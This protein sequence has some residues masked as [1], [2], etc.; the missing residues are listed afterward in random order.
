MSGGRI[1]AA[2]LLSVLFSSAARAAFTEPFEIVSNSVLVDGGAKETHFTLT[3]NRPPDF[4]GFDKLGRPNN[5]FQYF[6]DSDPSDDADGIFSGP[7]VVIIRG[8]EIR[9]HDNIPIRDS[10]N[11]GGQDFPH[12]EGWGP[13]RGQAD[14]AA[15]GP[16][17]NFTVPWSS[18]GETDGKFS[19]HLIAL[20]RG[21][22]TNE[23]SATVIALPP[24]VWALTVA[25][26]A[27]WWAAWR[28]RCARRAP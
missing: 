24:A 19:Y 3:F 17:V 2:V 13:I 26:P 4:F 21:A 11:P 8:P 25:A 20:N 10:L 12:A 27:A 5:A 6:Y 23:A 18:L 1:C 22:L 9:F 15:D 7:H 16:S 14:F 28:W